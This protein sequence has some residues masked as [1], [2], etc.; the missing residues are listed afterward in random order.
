M[1]WHCAQPM[2][3]S[4]WGQ[5]VNRS[6]WLWQWLP[7]SAGVMEGMLRTCPA[8]LNLLL[9]FSDRF[10]GPLGPWVLVSKAHL[11]FQSE[12]RY[13][14]MSWIAAEASLRARRSVRKPNH[15]EGYMAQECMRC[16]FLHTGMPKAT[17]TPYIHMHTLGHT[18]T[19]THTHSTQSEN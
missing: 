3:L 18:H 9:Q 12:P 5:R 6:L 7:G 17:Y 15:A 19:H 16:T 1:F 2:G 4:L 10:P 13:D 14:R 11:C 8:R